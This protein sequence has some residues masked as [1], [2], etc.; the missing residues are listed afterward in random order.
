MKGF[1]PGELQPVCMVTSIVDKNVNKTGAELV[2]FFLKIP[3]SFL[4]YRISFV[5]GLE[6]REALTYFMYIVIKLKNDCA[7][8][9]SRAMSCKGV[10]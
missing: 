6:W 9:P 4:N 5:E 1:N 7:G 8:L 3:K 2:F 10:L